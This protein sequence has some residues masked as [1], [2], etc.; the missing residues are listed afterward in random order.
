MKTV[1]IASSRIR[2]SEIG[3][4]VFFLQMYDWWRRRESE[5]EVAQLCP[6]LCDPMNCSPPGSPIHGIFQA[7][8][9]EWVPF[10]SPGGLPNL[11]MTSPKVWCYFLDSDQDTSSFISLPNTVSAN[12][13]TVKNANNMLMVL[14][15][16]FWLFADPL[17]VSWEPLGIWGPHSENLWSKILVIGTLSLTWDWFRNSLWSNSGQ[18]NLRASLSKSLWKSFFIAKK[19]H[20]K[21]MVLFFLSILPCQCDA[22]NHCNYFV[23]DE[24][25]QP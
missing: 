16:Y 2:L 9:L 8:V 14:W 17:K 10:L 11:G 20:K 24:A 15:K 1:F 19:R 22:W 21:E 12:V 18:W 13:T 4:L 5:S 7:R 25:N 6:T 23:I 3:L